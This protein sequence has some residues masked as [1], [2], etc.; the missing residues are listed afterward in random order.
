MGA[1]KFRSESTGLRRRD[2]L[3][4]QLGRTPRPDS[5][6]LIPGNWG[7]LR[8]G[9]MREKDDCQVSSETVG[10]H[11]PQDYGVSTAV[12][13]IGP[14]RLGLLVAD[15]S[16]ASGSK[17]NFNFWGRL[18]TYPRKWKLWEEIISQQNNKQRMKIGHLKSKGKGKKSVA[19]E[20]KGHLRTAGEKGAAEQAKAPE[21][22]NT[23]NKSSRIAS[24]AKKYDASQES[25]TRTG[26]RN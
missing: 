7:E 5:K 9:Q 13:T 3:T 26:T 25:I 23:T 24:L 14:R 4:G 15:L 10:Y 1:E 22:K 20:V 12:G 2:R 19:K 16:S 11:M 6:D 18:S 21:R 8:R 17:E